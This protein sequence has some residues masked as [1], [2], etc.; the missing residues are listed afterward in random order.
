LASVSLM[1]SS[2]LLAFCKASRT[3]CFFMR[4]LLG[5]RDRPASG[6]S[7][8]LS[9]PFGL[10]DFAGISTSST[11]PFSAAATSSGRLGKNL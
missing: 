5:V 8:F 2:P 10:V 11:L 3:G 4:N 1:N 9:S 7:G 6:Y